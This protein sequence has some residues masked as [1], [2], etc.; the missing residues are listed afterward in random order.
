MKIHHQKTVVNL[1]YIETCDN[2]NKKA[3]FLHRLIT[4]LIH[5]FFSNSICF[6]KH[7]QKYFANIYNFFWGKNTI[8]K[9]MLIFILVFNL[10]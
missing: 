6:A 2:Q 10:F 8:E 7:P 1:M 5:Q 9:N 4:I 3:T